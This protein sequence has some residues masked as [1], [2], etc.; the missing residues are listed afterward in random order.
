MGQCGT[1]SAGARILHAL[2]PPGDPRRIVDALLSVLIPSPCVACGVLLEHPTRGPVCSGCWLSI[3]PL[4]APSC[5]VIGAV[6]R[7]AAAGVY[8]GALRSIVHALK[9]DRRR[10]VAASLGAM[11]RERAGELLTDVDAAVP[12]P[13]HPLRH[14][15][16]G[17]NQAMDL[18]RHL[19]C[20]V[21]PA[22]RRIRR[23]ADQVDLPA[24]ERHANVRGA[25][26][27]TSAASMLLGKTVLL[28]DDVRTTGATLDAC[29]GV[30]K[31]CG[32]REIRALTAAAVGAERLKRS[33]APH[34]RSEVTAASTS[35]AITSFARSP[36][37]ANQPP[38]S[39]WRR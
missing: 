35:A 13:L 38:A 3:P 23:T 19:R 33:E 24:A 7:V 12:V 1:D 21:V 34:P 8:E 27:P 17:F 18:A 31:S 20:P 30:L 26:Q 28:V 36:S 9:Y 32:V 11:M 6:D 25:F 2:I 37:S 4:E 14:L 5:E 22:L 10:S 15:E 39:A 29:A 16:R